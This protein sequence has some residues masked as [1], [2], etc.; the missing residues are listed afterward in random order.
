MVAFVVRLAESARR[1]P[2][3]QAPR[4]PGNDAIPAQFGH[5]GEGKKERSGE[6]SAGQQTLVPILS[7]DSVKRKK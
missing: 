5:F 7:T 2:L 1:G 4:Q 3:E 6:K